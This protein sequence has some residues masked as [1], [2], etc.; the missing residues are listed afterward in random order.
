MVL[1]RSSLSTYARGF[2][3]SSQRES[4][5]DDEG[6]ESDHHGGR[7]EDERHEGC[8]GYRFS[9][10]FVVAGRDG[11]M[12]PGRSDGESGHGGWGDSTN[13]S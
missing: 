3:W 5:P 8:H 11:D 12:L 10:G 7:G 1:V 4:H 2:S 13:G 6:D 9:L